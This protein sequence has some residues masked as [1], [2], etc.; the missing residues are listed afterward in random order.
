MLWWGV[1]FQ[2]RLRLKWQCWR[3]EIRQRSCFR[4]KSDLK[5][6]KKTSIFLLKIAFFSLFFLKLEFFCWTLT[7][8]G[9][10]GSAGGRRQDLMTSRQQN[11]F[12]EQ[13]LSHRA[14]A[15]RK[16]KISLFFTLLCVLSKKNFKE[17]NWPLPTTPSWRRLSPRTLRE[18]TMAK[19][20]RNHKSRGASW[21]KRRRLVAA[22][23]TH[24]SSSRR[25]D[26]MRR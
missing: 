22:N 1:P 18:V 2:R 24:E 21:P 13:R 14:L 26:S 16:R 7:D 23:V 25:R 12:E 10:P 4:T 17:I 11:P 9:V 3:R 15:W 8:S 5:K 20:V 6:W 19:N